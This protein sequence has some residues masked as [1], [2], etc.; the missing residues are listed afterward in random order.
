MRD[1]IGVVGCGMRIREED[2]RRAWREEG[3]FVSF[4]KV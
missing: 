4:M 3:R 1:R 2:S